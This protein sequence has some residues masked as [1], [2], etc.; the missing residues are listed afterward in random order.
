[1][2]RLRHNVKMENRKTTLVTDSLNYDRIANLAYYYT[3]GKITDPLN[4]LTS[5][6]GQYSPATNDALFKNKVLIS[7]ALIDCCATIEPSA[8]G[9]A[10]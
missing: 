9:A 3:G 10:K 4:V 8:K 7:L 6:W 1:M 5:V 2:A